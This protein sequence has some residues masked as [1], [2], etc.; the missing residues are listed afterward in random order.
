MNMKLEV[1]ILPVSD[2]DPPKA[3][4]EK[5]GSVWISIT[6]RTKISRPP[7]YSSPIRRLDHLRR[8]SRRKP[9]R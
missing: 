1:V 8:E 7:I 3:F 9:A 5:L 2:I 6:P 4:Y